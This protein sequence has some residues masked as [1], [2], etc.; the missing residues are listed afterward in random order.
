MQRRFL[1]LITSSLVS[2]SLA[3]A[4]PGQYTAVTSNTYVKLSNATLVPYDPT[5]PKVFHAYQKHYHDPA[6]NRTLERQT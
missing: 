4:P 3:L 1:L 2:L 5:A 6:T